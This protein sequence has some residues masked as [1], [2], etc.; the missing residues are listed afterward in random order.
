MNQLKNFSA[1]SLQ[2]ITHGDSRH[3]EV[4]QTALALKGGCR[5]VQLRMKNATD[6]EVLAAGKA[7][8]KLCDDYGALLIL[9]DR[10]PL[11][12]PIRADGVHLGKNDMP[13]D[14]ARRQ[15][16]DQCIIGGTANTLDDIRRL[17]A[18]GA[19]YIGCG[20]FR[21]TTTKEHLAPLLGLD[22]YRRLVA[23]MHREGISLPMVAI[24]G[25]TL[26]DIA[27]I[28]DTGVQGVAISGA[29]AHAD[30]PDEATRAIVDEVRRLA[31][32]TTN[33]QSQ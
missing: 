23:S 20:P 24:G 6:E 15:L 31:R 2:F 21:F 16:G 28:M 22:G 8:R 33:Q 30:R 9:D 7:I 4:E 18:W 29:I 14:E 11:V 3:N 26:A 5:W 19:D 10:V 25:I 12:E 1:F 17:N 32:H 27:P 13:V